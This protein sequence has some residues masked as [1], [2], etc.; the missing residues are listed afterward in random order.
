V[1]FVAPG[2]NPVN[3]PRCTGPYEC[4]FGLKV[5]S[6]AADESLRC[7]LAVGSEQAREC[8]VTVGVAFPQVSQALSDAGQW[9][10]SS[11]WHNAKAQHASDL[12][13]LHTVSR[14]RSL[15][16]FSKRKWKEFGELGRR[17]YLERGNVHVYGG[18]PGDIGR[19]SGWGDLEKIFDMF[20]AWTVHGRTL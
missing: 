18:E 13:D 16:S 8:Y 12:T 17:Y 20:Q 11:L 5:A 3:R 7:S 2:L 14:T 4:E 19:V 15:Y 10:V 1:D 9:K 6:S